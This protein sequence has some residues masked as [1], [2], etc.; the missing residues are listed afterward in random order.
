MTLAAHRMILGL[1]PVWVSAQRN[2]LASVITV[3]GFP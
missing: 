1:G 2:A 3:I